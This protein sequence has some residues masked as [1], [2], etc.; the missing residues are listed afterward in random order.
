MKI[1]IL[2]RWNSACGVSLHAELIG[3]EFVRKGHRLVVFAPRAVRRVAPDED[4]VVRCYSDEGEEMPTFFDPRPFLEEDYDIFV[5]ERIEWAPIKHLLGVFP[6]IRR[7]AK[8]VYVVH[9]RKPPA[10]RLFYQFDWDA[11][12]CFDDRYRRQWS[13]IRKFRDRIRVIPYPTGPLRRGDRDRA[14]RELSLPSE[15]RILFSYG[16][17]PELHV[18]PVLKHLEELRRELEF[19]FLVLVS[20]EAR[21]GVPELDFMVVRREM[22]PLD[23]LYTYLHASDACLI[24]KEPGEVREG[25]VVV[26]SSVLMCMGAL[27]PIVTSDTEFVSFLGKEVVK[28]RGPEDMKK[29]LKE[30]L[31]GGRLAEETVRAAER[32]VR[33]N[34]P[35]RVAERFLE[36]FE[37]L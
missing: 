21:R 29:V 27:R 6:E 5:A 11:V 31:L 30:V 20:P 8:T 37:E 9:E 10:N 36:L 26:S 4:Y 13:S 17:A 18:L 33:E 12:V 35:E 1:A 32:Y 23:R 3:R 22:P 24:H 2:S 16:W 19:T 34:S 7:K 15:G 28:Y 14:R 25:E